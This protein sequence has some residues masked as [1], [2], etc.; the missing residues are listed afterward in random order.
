M[1]F[2]YINGKFKRAKVY[3]IYTEFV[4]GG[5]ILKEK[6]SDYKKCNTVVF[7]IA[8]AYELIRPKYVFPFV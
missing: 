3:K 7:I 2:L 5:K 8:F 1:Y 4:K 6:C